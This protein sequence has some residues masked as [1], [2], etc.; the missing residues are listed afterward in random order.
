MLWGVAKTKLKKKKGPAKLNYAVR[1]LDSGV[2]VGDATL[3]GTCGGSGVLVRFSFL[4]RGLI[5]KE[6][7]VWHAVHGV[8]KSQ[9]QLSNWTTKTRV[10]AVHWSTHCDMG[11]NLHE[12]SIS[13]K[14]KIWKPPKCPSTG[15]WINKLW[16]V[17]PTE[18]YSALKRHS[19]YGNSM[20]ETKELCWVKEARPKKH[21]SCATPFTQNST[22]RTLMSSDRKQISG[23]LGMEEREEQKGEVTKGGEG[24]LWGDG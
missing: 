5:V 15:K 19:C 23:Y 24:N 3:G 7:K 21:T 10:C 18:H 14:S 9:T 4:I 1:S 12:F 20:E 13:S 17:H 16:N 6:R 22:K 11:T 2:E 8:A